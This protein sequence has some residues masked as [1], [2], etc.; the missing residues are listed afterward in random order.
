MGCDYLLSLRDYLKKSEKMQEEMQE[1][2]RDVERQSFKVDQT[3][4]ENFAEKCADVTIS[5]WESLAEL[6]I[7][8]GEDIKESSVEMLAICQKA[9]KQ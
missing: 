5:C 8:Y 1:L 7:R 2:R 4:S 3:T 9:S 6:E